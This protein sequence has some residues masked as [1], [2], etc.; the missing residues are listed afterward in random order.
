[1]K[2]NLVNQPYQWKELDKPI[3][4]LHVITSLMAEPEHRADFGLYGGA[5]LDQKRDFRTPDGK[6]EYQSKATV[7]VI[8]I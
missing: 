8:L 7:T 6:A 2:I 1:L 5:V 3:D 4:P